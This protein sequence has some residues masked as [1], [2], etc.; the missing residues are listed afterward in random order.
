MLTTNEAAEQLGV[1]RRRVLAFITAGR[2][3]ANKCGRDWFVHESDL[4]AFAAKPRKPG[5]PR[6]EMGQ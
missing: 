3:P 6:K 5:K 4:A 1:T 2:L